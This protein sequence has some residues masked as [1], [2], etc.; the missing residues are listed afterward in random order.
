MQKHIS[1]YTIEELEREI[2]SRR[3]KETAK[4]DP[5]DEINWNDVHKLAVHCHEHPDPDDD[6]QYMFEAVMLTVYGE[7]YFIKLNGS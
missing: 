3:F 5:I 6:P 1:N 2:K 4:P 7:D